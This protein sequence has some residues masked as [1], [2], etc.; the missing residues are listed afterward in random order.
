MRRDGC[1]YCCTYRVK[2]DWGLF[3]HILDILH[4]EKPNHYSWL[5][6]DL[7][8]LQGGGHRF[9]SCTAHQGLQG[10]ASTACN[11]FSIVHAPFPTPIRI[12]WGTNLHTSKRLMT[13]KQK[14]LPD[15]MGRSWQ[16]SCLALV[17]ILAP[18]LLH[19]LLH[20]PKSM[21]YALLLWH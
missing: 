20:L 17:V 10:V 2:E 9:K 19:M 18:A 1:T 8:P 4:A 6:A 21:K 15:L 14:F 5:Y 13:S 16:L 12:I 3:A 7:P 11:P